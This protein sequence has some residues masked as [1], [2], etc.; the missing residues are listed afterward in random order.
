[1]TF[2]MMKTICPPTVGIADVV[3]DEPDTAPAFG[4]TT[5]RAI[6]PMTIDVPTTATSGRHRHIPMRT[7]VTTVATASQKHS[8][9]AKTVM[10]SAVALALAAGFATYSIHLASAELI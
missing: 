1:M 9:A 7:R 5:G 10:S 3:R 2:G 4:S 8:T 6:S